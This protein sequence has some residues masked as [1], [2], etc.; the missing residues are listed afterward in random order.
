[1]DIQSPSL[2]SHMR[3]LRNFQLLMGRASL[4]SLSLLSLSQALCSDSGLLNRPQETTP[5]APPELIVQ[6]PITPP[7]KALPTSHRS[8]SNTPAFQISVLSSHYPLN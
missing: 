4:G 5:N 1:M 7:S 3:T 6:T 8:A 2:H